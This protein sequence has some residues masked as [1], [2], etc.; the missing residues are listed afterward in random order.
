MITKMMMTLFS[1]TAIKGSSSFWYLLTHGERFQPTRVLIK[2]WTLFAWNKNN[3]NSE[4]ESD[5][6]K[7]E[8]TSPSPPTSLNPSLL[9]KAPLHGLDV[10]LRWPSE[11][12]HLP[13][14]MISC[15]TT[16][17]WRRSS[18]WSGLNWSNL[19]WWL[20]VGRPL[21]GEDLVGGVVWTGPTWVDD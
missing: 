14:L 5:K 8:T 6:N 12:R 18:W 2:H 4:S 10:W 17:P 16:P 3:C 21:H 7:T 1:R 15:W 13:E 11:Q 9:S 20:V 19:S